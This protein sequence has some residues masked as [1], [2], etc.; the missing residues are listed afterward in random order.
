MGGLWAAQYALAVRNS[1]AVLT[2]L[3]ESS[4]R[5]ATPARVRSHSSC[6]SWRARDGRSQ[7]TRTLSVWT[8]CMAYEQLEHLGE[9][10]VLLKAKLAGRRFMQVADGRQV[11]LARH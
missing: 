3:V 11:N 6:R 1:S 2:H 7:S 4:P 9:R 8:L 5:M 10:R